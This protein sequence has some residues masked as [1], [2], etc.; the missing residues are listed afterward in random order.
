MF[1]N[2]GIEL[3]EQPESWEI[4]PFLTV[5]PVGDYH[6]SSICQYN[7]KS[8]SP[9]LLRQAAVCLKKRYLAHV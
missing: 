7:D 6:C 3:S 1:L 2:G 5:A 4:L 8:L 9:V